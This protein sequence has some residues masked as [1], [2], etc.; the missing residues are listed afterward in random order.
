MVVAQDY[1]REPLIPLSGKYE[2][3]NTPLSEVGRDKVGVSDFLLERAEEYFERFVNYSHVYGILKNEIERRGIVLDGVGIDVG[4][5]FGNTVIPLLSHNPNLRMI[6]TDI[7]PDLLAIL[8]REAIGRD[9]GDRCAVVAM[10][11]QA[12]YFQPGCVDFVFGNAIL[13]HLQN[14][15]AAI[16]NVL[17]AL[18][19][20]GTAIFCEPFQAGHAIQHMA[21]DRILMEARY[22]GESTPGLQFMYALT[23]DIW[24]RTH[25][26]VPADNGISWEQLDDKWLFSKSYFD[27]IADSLNCSAIEVR[28]QY[29]NDQFLTQHTHVAVTQYGGLEPSSVPDWAWDVLNTYDNDLLSRDLKSEIVMEGVVTITR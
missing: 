10:D 29:F 12:D 26:K 11:A 15:E 7:S 16:R 1:F 9:M 24:A 5:G 2:G 3:V 25:Q 21:Y 20:G 27:R 6:A 22:R 17:S 18:R 14:P 23:R 8:R 28:P 4:S 13:H 19:P